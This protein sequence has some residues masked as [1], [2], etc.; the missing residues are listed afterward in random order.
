MRVLGM[1]G[2]QGIDPAQGLGAAPGLGQFLDF[3]Q[4]GAGQVGQRGCG[5][6]QASGQ[7]GCQP[8]QRQPFHRCTTASVMVTVCS[9]TFW[10]PPLAVVG[11][12][13]ILSTTSMPDTTL[14][15]TV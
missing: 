2:D 8:V 13:R 9:G 14:P 3:G 5:G 11:S 10:C 6:D 1:F 4:A 12:A 7:R 15:N